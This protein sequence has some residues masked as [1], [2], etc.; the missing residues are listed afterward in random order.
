MHVKSAVRDLPCS[1]RDE[2]SLGAT[3]MSQPAGSGEALLSTLPHDLIKSSLEYLP[4]RSQQ[5][6]AREVNQEWSR[7]VADVVESSFGEGGASTV[8]NGEWMPGTRLELSSVLCCISDMT[9]TFK[10]SIRRIR[11]LPWGAK[12][13]VGLEFILGLERI[14]MLE[15]LNLACTGITSVAHFLCCKSLKTLDL[16]G[17]F[18]LTDDGILGLELI[19]T[20]EELILNATKVTTVAHLSRCKA[21]RYLDLCGCQK[22]TDQGILGL[23]RIPTLEEL[24]LCRSNLSTVTNFSSCKVLKKL[25]L[26]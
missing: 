10:A 14:P 7:A 1:T 12:D 13:W 23:E 3:H 18:K 6:K 24:V 15:E 9:D 17:C 19:P 21:L 16:E 8:Q 5:L 4:T 11:F 22:L 20:L 26:V 25:F 2:S